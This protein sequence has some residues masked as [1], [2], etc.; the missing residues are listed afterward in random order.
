MSKSLGNVIS[1]VQD[2]IPRYGADVLRLW[3]SSEDYK[4]DNTIGFNIL[5][6][7]SES[8][9]KIRNTFRYILGNLRDGRF[10]PT[11]DGYSI[12]NELDKWILHRLAILGGQMKKAYEE[13]EFHTAYQEALKFCTIDLSQLYFDMIRDSLYSDDNPDR[14]NSV[15]PSR[16]S[17]LAALKIILDHLNVW[18]API[19]SF[20]MEEVYQT[21]EKKNNKSIF[22]ELWPDCSHWVNQASI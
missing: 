20:T 3:V 8:Y 9:R 5:D 11:E 19:L 14:P 17:S 15:S 21:L 6:R 4:S 10:S 1:P 13:Y 16:R 18:F 22:Q 2:I 7:L 12:T